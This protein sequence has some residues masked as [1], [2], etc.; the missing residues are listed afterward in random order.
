MNPWRV[1]GPLLVTAASLGGA[2]C[3]RTPPSTELLSAYAAQATTNRSLAAI[4]M[5]RAFKAG[6]ITADE[7]LSR[8]LDALDRGEDVTAFCG[9]VLDMLQMVESSLP[10]SPEME[11]F[12]FR[13]GRL[14]CNSG[15]MALQKGRAEEAATLMLAGP[16]RWQSEA[17]FRRYPDHD[18][19]IAL[20]LTAQG[21]RQ[22]A[23]AWLRA[24]PE[25]DGIALETLNKLTER[26]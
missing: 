21:R 16:K 14:A 22:E 10:T 23:I 11:L 24:R 4:G 7:T 18:A 1:I 15:A 8:A 6:Q 5:A 2:A 9:A 20:T 26:H 13:I 12:W 25:L 17:Y 19:L 3:S